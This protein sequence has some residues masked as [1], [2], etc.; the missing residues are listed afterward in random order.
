MVQNVIDLIGH[1]PLVSL[2][3]MTGLPIYFCQ[4]R[5]FESWRQH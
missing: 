1:T 3:K 5:V 4:G 2:E